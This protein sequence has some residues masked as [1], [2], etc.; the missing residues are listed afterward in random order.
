MQRNDGSVGHKSGEKLVRA[1]PDG[2]LKQ[3][4]RKFEDTFSAE[5]VVLE[6]FFSPN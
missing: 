3:P 5:S 6:K 2:V 1:C 4:V